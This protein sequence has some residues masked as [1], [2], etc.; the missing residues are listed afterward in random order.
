[1]RECLQLIDMEDSSSDTLK[2]LMLRCTISPLILR[3]LDGRRF[4]AY[5]FSLH[6]SFVS[7]LHSAVKNQVCDCNLDGERGCA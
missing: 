7:S 1:M 5:V 3:T 6:A 2:H 4:L